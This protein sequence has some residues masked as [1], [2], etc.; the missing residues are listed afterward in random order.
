MNQFGLVHLESKKQKARDHTY[1]PIFPT[2]MTQDDIRTVKILE[3]R[4]G[5]EEET[6]LVKTLDVQY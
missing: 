1:Q 6:E 3:A 5:E 2:E 4:E